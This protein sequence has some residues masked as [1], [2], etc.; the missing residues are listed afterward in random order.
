MSFTLPTGAHSPSWKRY[1]TS[2]VHGEQL[3][4]NEFFNESSGPCLPAK[5]KSTDA[6]R[7]SVTSTTSMRERPLSWNKLRIRRISKTAARE[8]RS[9]GFKRM[10]TMKPLR[11]PFRD[12]TEL[13]LIAQ[14]FLDKSHEG[15]NQDYCSAVEE[16]LNEFNRWKS[17]HHLPSITKKDF[18]SDQKLCENSNEAVIRRTLMVSIIDRGQLH[19]LF[20]Y[21]CEGLWELN[22]EH[23]LPVTGRIEEVELPKP[24][25]AMFFKSAAFTRSKGWKPCSKEINQCMRPDGGDDRCFPFL[26]MEVDQA[27]H[28]LY[29]AHR[30]NLYS[31]SQALYNIFICMSNAQKEAA[32]FDKVRVFSIVLNA[33]DM[34]LRVH[35]AVLEEDDC[36]SFHFDDIVSLVKYERDQACQLVSKVVIEYAQKELHGILL[37]TYQNV[38]RQEQ[39]F[40]EIR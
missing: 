19:S 37:E 28:G 31:A 1:V 23:V 16:F 26:F 33:Q 39:V 8:K 24:D 9:E 11:L 3:W 4:P 34:S 7:S 29:L 14:Q 18:D 2:W 30:A 6:F 40:D 22:S 27:A 21:N 36:L 20:V 5:K 25:L 32:F 35:R 10:F 12:T 15:P 38:S 13:R 17:A